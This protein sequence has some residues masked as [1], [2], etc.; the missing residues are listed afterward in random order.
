PEHV[1]ADAPDGVPARLFA[2]ERLGE[3][4]YLYATV[5]GSGE[6]VVVRADPERDWELGQMLSLGA[7]Q[8]RIH[9]FGADGQRL[10]R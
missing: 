3:G 1:N 6:Q 4:T 8:A 5:N 7:P 9:L 10:R 2:V